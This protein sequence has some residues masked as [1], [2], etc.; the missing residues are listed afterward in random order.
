MNCDLSCILDNLGIQLRLY[1]AK[2]ETLPLAM[3]E[4]WEPLGS[5]HDNLKQIEAHRQLVGKRYAALPG[6]QRGK[7][8]KPT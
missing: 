1:I 3:R 8:E 2:I 7:E 6:P 4:P 5:L